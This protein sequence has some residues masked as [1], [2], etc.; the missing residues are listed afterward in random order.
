MF[1]C[2]PNLIHTTKSATVH[3]IN[4]HFHQ[5]K[6]CLSRK[7]AA[8]L[9]LSVSLVISIK[10]KPMSIAI[11]LLIVLTLNEPASDMWETV[12]FSQSHFKLLTLPHVHINNDIF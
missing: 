10:R 8:L 3:T 5:N 11:F 2:I 12:S 6:L 7:K 1:G 9:S 4:D